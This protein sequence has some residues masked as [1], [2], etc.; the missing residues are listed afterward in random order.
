MI[1]HRQKTILDIIQAAPIENQKELAEA[2]EQRGIRAS[3]ATLSRDIAKLKLVKIK[4]RDGRARYAQASDAPAS[5]T[6]TKMKE[7]L[8]K[9]TVSVDSVQNLVVVHTMPG[10]APGVGRVIDEMEHPAMVGCL[11]GNDTV[12]LILRTSQDAE[13]FR[14]MLEMLL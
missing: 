13:D 1:D 14:R 10:L 7:V 3:Q 6:S 5:G 11:A 2:L 4:T 8:S 9:G 12:V